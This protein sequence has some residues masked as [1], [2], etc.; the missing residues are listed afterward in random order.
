[1]FGDCCLR[2]ALRRLPQL[3]LQRRYET[4]RRDDHAAWL[5]RFRFCTNRRFGSRGRRRRK[6]GDVG[7]SWFRP[8]RRF[9]GANRHLRRHQRGSN[10]SSELRHRGAHFSSRKPILRRYRDAPDISR[11]F[12]FHAHLLQFA[13]TVRHVDGLHLRAHGRRPRF[14]VQSHH[15][16]CHPRSHSIVVPGGIAASVEVEAGGDSSLDERLAHAVLAKDNQ[17]DGTINASAAAGV[18]AI[19]VAWSAGEIGLTHISSRKIKFGLLFP[20]GHA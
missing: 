16:Q 13:R 1:M 6:R 18:F 17:R 15:L 2:S 9:I 3:P 20:L 5:R 10:C 8:R 12:Q 14:D 19:H 4:I 11:G 7:H